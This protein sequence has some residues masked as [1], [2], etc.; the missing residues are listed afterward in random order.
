MKKTTIITGKKSDRHLY[1]KMRN[2]VTKLNKRKKK[3]YFEDQVQKVGNDSKKLWNV[4]NQLTGDK[5]KINL[6]FLETDNTFITKPLDIA[7]YI[8]D[9]FIS[10]R[11]LKLTTL[12]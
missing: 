12:Q 8:N 2:S 4:L 9:C 11:T 6:A 10:S 3:T 5:N 7:N 1:R